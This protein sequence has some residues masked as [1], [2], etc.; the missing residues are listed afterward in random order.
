M[1]LFKRMLPYYILTLI[2]VTLASAAASQSVTA[3]SALMSSAE[4][5]PRPTVVVDPGHGGEDGG[6]VSPNGVLESGLNLE[7]GLRTRDLLRFLG[8]SVRMTRETD[9]SIYSPEAR[10]VSEK[11]VSDLK[12]RVALV[13]ETE[14]AILVSIH[15]NMFSE[16]KYRGAQVFYAQTAG[17]RE[18]AEEL[19]SLFDT[20]LDPSNHRQAK[21]SEAVYLL[22]RIHCPGVLVECGFLS[23]PEEERLLQT[24]AH[25]KKLSA[26]I[27]AALTARLAAS[28][29][30]KI[31]Q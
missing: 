31:S 25:Q 22:S 28:A 13:N 29:A 8:L 20:D 26:A 1:R 9:L 30:E 11:K 2:L 16:S 12:N 19:Q 15:Q 4:R 5:S 3:V 27:C 7:I 23:N 21:E 17:S 10:T 6:A 18:L 14:D 24:E